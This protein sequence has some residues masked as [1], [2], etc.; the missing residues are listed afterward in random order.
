MAG[1][2]LV[3]MGV[4]RLGNLIQYI[5]YPVTTGFTTG[6]ATV[7]ATLQIKDV[8]GLRPARCPNTSSRSSARSGTRA[9]TAHV[10]ELA[11][12]AV[13]FALA[14]SCLPR[15]TRKVPAP[16][17]AIAGVAAAASRSLAP[18]LP[19]FD[20]ATIGTRFHTIVDG[21]DVAGIPSRAARRPRCRGATTPLDV[22]A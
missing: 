17:I 2:M 10:S 4:A 12:A 19:A 7:I 5:P 11:V 18:L 15:V 13:T 22:T 8:L 16:L 1:V 20:V 3:V 9:A 14:A 6:I 21:V